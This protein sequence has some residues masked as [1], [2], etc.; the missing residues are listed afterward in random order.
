MSE[1]QEICFSGKFHQTVDAKRRVSIPAYYHGQVQSKIFHITRGP[2]HNLFVYPRE[3]FLKM[4]Q[5]INENFGGRGEKDVEKRI[6]FQE[7][8][9]DAQPVQCDQQGRVTVPS[10]FLEY[11]NIKSK[12]LIVG[13][14]NK[15]VFWNPDEYERFIKSSS[16]TPQ[17]RVGEF[18]WA[19]GE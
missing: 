7:T 11:A 3:I 6:Y 9:G 4:A 5:R 8:I 13:L 17:Q 14:Y 2:D 10:E 12:V 19:E 16:M 1:L 15:L 18:G